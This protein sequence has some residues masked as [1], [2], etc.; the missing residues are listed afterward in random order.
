MDSVDSTATFVLATIDKSL[1]YRRAAKELQCKYMEPFRGVQS[2]M[3]GA[4]ADQSW[5]QMVVYSNRRGLPARRPT[6]V[7][8]GCADYASAAKINNFDATIIHK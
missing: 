5:Y 8:E 6:I 3:M 4:S 1:V 2:I 7:A